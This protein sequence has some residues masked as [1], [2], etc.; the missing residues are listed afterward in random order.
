MNGFIAKALGAASLI[1]GLAAGGCVPYRERV[2][3]CYPQRYNM[4]ARREVIDA[5]APQ[6]QNGHFLDQTIW[7]Y[8]FEAGTDKLSAGGLAHLNYLTRRR[9]EP[10]TRLFLATAHDIKYDPNEADKF[11]EARREL[12]TRRVAAIQRYL[13]VQ[14]AGRPVNFD[15][16][17]HDPAEQYIGG[18]YAANMA[19]QL[20]STGASIG[21][22]V[23][24]G[25]GGATTGGSGGAGSTGSASSGAYSSTGG[26]TGGGSSSGGGGTS[27]GNTP[28]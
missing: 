11:V 5:F 14:T 3:P 1:G 6:V 20:R 16:V 25:G 15:I 7:N 17:V 24:G 10:D 22:G 21:G 19:R 8:H 23:S 27:G 28:R 13:A 4:V 12:D 9:P 2:D 26:S 18:D